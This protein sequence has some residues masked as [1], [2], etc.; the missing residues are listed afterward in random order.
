MDVPQYYV[1]LA[2]Y[3]FTNLPFLFFSSK[4]LA[5]CTVGK[6]ED[7]VTQRPTPTP[8]FH[9]RKGEISVGPRVSYAVIG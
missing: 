9:T 3:R 2:N 8:N 7:K 1:N 4:S 6:E 5:W